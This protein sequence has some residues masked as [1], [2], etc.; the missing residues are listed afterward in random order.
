MIDIQVELD[1]FINIVKEKLKHLGIT[2][3]YRIYRGYR[4]KGMSTATHIYSFLLKDV[5]NDIK[6]SIDVVDDVSEGDLALYALKW[7]DTG[8]KNLV[9]VRRNCGCSRELLDYI[10]RKYATEVIFLPYPEASL[11]NEEIFGLLSS[12]L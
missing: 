12:R 2:S 4:I 11:D 1:D 7:I 5:S 9:I 3:R 10:K 6:V 8:V